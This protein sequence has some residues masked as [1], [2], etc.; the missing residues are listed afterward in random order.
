MITM[1]E[2]REQILDLLYPAACIG[3]GAPGAVLCGRCMR[4][5]APLRGP[6]CP[7][8]P[9]NVGFAFSGWRAG[10]AYS[11]LGRE[12]V[13]SL[14]SAER[15][16]A[17]PL[18]GMMLDAAGNDPEYL[19]PDAVTWVPSEKRKIAARGYN[20]AELLAIEFTRL[21]G[22]PA[23]ELLSKTRA[24]PDQ[25]AV[26]REERWRNVAGCFSVPP[27]A[28]VPTRVLLIDDVLTTGATA[29][30]CARALLSAGAQTVYIMV[31]ART[32]PQH[33]GWRLPK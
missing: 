20:P 7:R 2:I 16:F 12:M 9:G 30:S 8:L 18:A 15:T 31:A 29:D 4:G 19:A 25:D 27:G 26:S 6:E 14:K 11:G 23:R 32:L 13:L 33:I 28:A 21:T 22:R 3:C 17:R 10:C 5:C 1:T 24:T